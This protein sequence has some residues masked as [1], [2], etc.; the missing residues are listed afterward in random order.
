MVR[1]QQAAGPLPDLRPSRLEVFDEKAPPKGGF[2][3]AWRSVPV[4]VPSTPELAAGK[5]VVRSPPRVSIG[6][7]GI[8]TLRVDVRP[9][10][11]RLYVHA[12][13]PV[14]GWRLV[15]VVVVLYDLAVHRRRGR[16]DVRVSFGW[17]G[18]QVGGYGRHSETQ[19]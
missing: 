13:L 10:H 3:E 17:I 12:A 8:D 2:L 19:R 6:I 5:E 16:R 1:P 9:V 14:N 15:V 7:A 11:P 18:P 4:P